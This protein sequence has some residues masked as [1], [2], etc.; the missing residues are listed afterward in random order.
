[1]GRRPST[2]MATDKKL[3]RSKSGLRMVAVNEALTSPLMLCEPPWIPDNEC[4]DCMQ[5]KSRFNYLKRR[6][7][8]R[9]CGKCFCGGCCEAK[10]SLPRMC[11][12]DPVRQCSA[13]LDVTRKENEF[14]E[15]HLKILSS[16]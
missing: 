4:P 6:H 10:I 16:G 11:F 3:V 7:H 14:F 9:R 8:C 12:V 1:M 13:C 2:N 5:C 15:R